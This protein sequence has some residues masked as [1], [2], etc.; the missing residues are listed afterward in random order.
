MDRL[1]LAGTGTASKLDTAFCLAE[2][3]AE[4]SA[5]TTGFGALEGAAA[6]DVLVP[7]ALGSTELP[8][9]AELAVAAEDADV[10]AGCDDTLGSVDGTAAKLLVTVS[11]NG[12]AGAV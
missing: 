4:L 12:E 6:G 1:L 11:G 3:V 9:F 2:A 5:V 8:G 7:G 10:A